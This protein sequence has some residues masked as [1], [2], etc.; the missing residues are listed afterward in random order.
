MNPE[1]SM[2]ES[3]GRLCGPCCGPHCN[4]DE[5]EMVQGKLV[6]EKIETEMEIGRAATYC[7]GM[8]GGSSL[9][10]APAIANATYDA[11]GNRCTQ[12]PITPECLLAALT[13]K[14]KQRV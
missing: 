8:T 10:T 9:M 3:T 1:Y 6:D 5:I 7:A 13:E 4:M 2:V 11:M 12:L 14:R